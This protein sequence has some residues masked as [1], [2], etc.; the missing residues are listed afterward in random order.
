M[1]TVVETP[2]HPPLTATRRWPWY[3]REAGLWALLLTMAGIDAAGFWIVL[4]GV[5]F[6]EDADLLA[7]VVVG[8]SLASV[9]F[10]HIAGHVARRRHDGLPASWVVFGVSAAMWAGLA[11]LLTYIRA[12]DTQAGGS[13][14]DGGAGI[15]GGLAQDDAASDSRAG[16]LLALLL[17]ALYVGTGLVAYLHAWYRSGEAENAQAQREMDY[18]RALRAVERAEVEAEARRRRVEDEQA[19]AD[20][21][22]RR[23]NLHYE[24]NDAAAELV[25]QRILARMAERLNDPAATDALTGGVLPERDRGGFDVPRRPDDN[26]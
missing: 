25:N 10:P 9:V 24:S 4:S 16:L 19:E 11:G 1:T 23:Q 3:L 18:R 8:C 17:V 20:A 7:I 15:L 12:T 21:L 6:F 26:G 5:A 13:Q 14:A 2:A 22:A